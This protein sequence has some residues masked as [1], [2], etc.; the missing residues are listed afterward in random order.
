MTAASEAAVPRRRR[1]RAARGARDPSARHFVH[2]SP[3]DDDGPASN[4]AR[5]ATPSRAAERGPG[6]AD[7]DP[8]ASPPRRRPIPRTRRRARLA[9]AADLTDREA[10]RPDSR[11]PS[12]TSG[13][14]GPSRDDAAPPRRRAAPP[15][16]IAPRSRQRLRLAP[17]SACCASTPDERRRVR[18]APSSRRT[19]MMMPPGGAPRSSPAGVPPRNN[20]ASWTIARRFAV[21]ERGRRPRC[22]AAHRGAMSDV[23]GC[24]AASARRAA[25][26]TPSRSSTRTTRRAAGA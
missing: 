17:R 4:D 24:R 3:N 11:G 10:A 14:P 25:P 21:P 1:R 20:R 8:R 9:P 6:A 26:S 12:R 15:G 16:R 19:M 5:G 23:R 22:G 13:P 18:S 7:E 2:A